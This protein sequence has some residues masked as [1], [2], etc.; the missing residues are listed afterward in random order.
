MNSGKVF[1]V[2]LSVVYVAAIFISYYKSKRFMTALLIT[3]LQG[4]CALFA[5]N[6]IGKYISVHIPIN[7]YTLGL[8]SVGGVS[9]VIMVLLC[10]IFL[11]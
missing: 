4:L 8:S 7:T 10:D 6:L 9:G 2:I 11:H 1:L 3:T 5:V